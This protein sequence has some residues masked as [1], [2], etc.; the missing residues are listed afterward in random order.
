MSVIRQH[1]PLPTAM[2]RQTQPG[3]H[4]LAA[5]THP[6]RPWAEADA[7]LRALLRPVVRPMRR[8]W[9]GLSGQSTAA[10]FA[11]LRAAQNDLAMALQE[12]LSAQAGSYPQAVAATRR[13]VWISPW[14]TRCGIAEYSRLMLAALFAR[15]SGWR[16]SVLHD[17]RPTSPQI[18]APPNVAARCGFVAGEA[19]LAGQLARGIVAERADCVVIQHHAALIAWQSLADLLLHPAVAARRMVVVLHNT[20][21]ILGLPEPVRAY[22][23]R[24]LHGADR[25]I[26]HTNRDMALLHA[27]GLNNLQRIMHGCSPV[28]NA[29]SARPM[30]PDGAPLIGCTGFLLP[31][32]GAR[33]LIRAAAALR[34]SWPDLRLR[35]VMARYDSRASELEFNACV[36]LARKLRFERQIEWH[37]SFLPQRRVME[38]LAQC[39]LLVLPYGKTQESASGAARIAVASGVPTLVTDQPIFDDLGDA[40]GRL[41]DVVAG[42]LA[43]QLEEWLHDTGRRGALQQRARLWGAAHDWQVVSGELD[44]L[45]NALVPACPPIS[46]T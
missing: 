33:N 22:L 31:H 12:L 2:P 5:M 28:A 16:V 14:Q 19:G 8:W 13:L 25:V 46:R 1:S 21:E 34:S 40:V 9:R 11:A 3:W 24:A 23:H 15:Q 44:A 4:G 29:P 30:P 38:L 45:L 35:L 18:A 10:Q 32:K 41:N 27:F 7:W 37:T 39:D 20:Q 17:E 36:A 42:G 43:G 6:V 26:V